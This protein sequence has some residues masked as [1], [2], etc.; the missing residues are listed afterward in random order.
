MSPL[1]L[2][3]EICVTH[4]LFRHRMCQ[5]NVHR[6]LNTGSTIKHNQ[7]VWKDGGDTLGGR[8]WRKGSSVPCCVKQTTMSSWLMSPLR[9]TGMKSS[10]TSSSTLWIC[11]GKNTV[12]SGGEKRTSRGSQKKEKKSNDTYNNLPKFTAHQPF[13]GWY[14]L[15]FRLW[16]SEQQLKC[17][18]F[19]LKW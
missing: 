10:P 4:Y 8:R 14:R 17:F 9:C 16:I 12:D 3:T 2:C 6:G 18:F 11:S 19:L 13:K 1:W 5:E 7:S 15:L